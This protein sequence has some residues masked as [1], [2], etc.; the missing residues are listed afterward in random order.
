[1]FHNKG[2]TCSRAS[3]TNSIAYR[4]LACLALIYHAILRAIRWGTTGPCAGGSYKHMRVHW[5]AAFRRPV[6]QTPAHRFGSPYRTF[7]YGRNSY[8]S[9]RLEVV[10]V[11]FR[12]LAAGVWV[13]FRH[14][15][16]ESWL[17]GSGYVLCAGVRVPSVGSQVPRTAWKTV[18]LQTHAWYTTAWPP[19]AS[20]KRPLEALVVVLLLCHFFL[21]SDHQLSPSVA[22]LP[23][24]T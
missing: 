18:L 13:P 4:P 16:H 5:L 7:E 6:T 2:P 10:P 12:S 8:G 11:L 3:L 24:S 19:S 9:I 23:C 22:C 15:R 20:G 14:L 17:C 21:H 1:M